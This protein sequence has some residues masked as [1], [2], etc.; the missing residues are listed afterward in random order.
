MAALKIEMQQKGAFQIKGSR[1][2][3]KTPSRAAKLAN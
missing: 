3:S 1:P 2:V